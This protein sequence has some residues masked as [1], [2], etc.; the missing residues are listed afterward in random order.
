MTRKITIFALT[1]CLLLGSSTPVAL[2]YYETDPSLEYI[3]VAE[4]LVGQYDLALGATG[5]S[6]FIGGADQTTTSIDNH[7]GLIYSNSQTGPGYANING[8]MQDAYLTVMANIAFSTGGVKINGYTDTNGKIRTLTATLDMVK[9][10][11]FREADRVAR[12]AADTI[13]ATTSDPRK[14]VE[15]A[16]QYLIDNVSYPKVI[17]NSKDTLWTAYGAL[18]NKEAVCQ[19]YAAAFHLILQHLKIPVVNDF[20]TADGQQHVW[21]QVLIDGQWLYVDVTFNDPIISGGRPTQADLNKFSK[22]FLLLTK[23]AFYAKGKHKAEFTKYVEAVKDIFYRNELNAE[24]NALKTA[25]L[26]LGDD[27]GYRMEDGLSRAEMAVMLTRVVGGSASVEANPAAYAALSPFTDVP[28]WAKPYVG[29]C[30]SQGLI[31]GIGN[32]LYGSTNQASKLDYSTVLLRATNATGHTYQTSDKRAV[33][34]GYL[35]LAR[36]A[37]SDLTRGDVVYMT[38]ALWSQGKIGN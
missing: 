17:D 36:A 24:A 11:Q 8:L 28:D 38:H 30:V 33:E 25:G 3:R 35:S 20:G 37:F 4:R 21:N 22:E 7:T 23:E 9:A 18:V 10:A 32:N 34:L 29:Y 2:A 19:G 12:S 1:L 16:N 6:Y 14:M 13:K 26:F 31:V 27:K 5:A 15:L